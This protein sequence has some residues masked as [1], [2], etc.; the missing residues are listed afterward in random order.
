MRSSDF[1]NDT[2]V[3]FEFAL[4]FKGKKRNK[5]GEVCYKMINIGS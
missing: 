2:N 5:A 4:R 3:T 1:F